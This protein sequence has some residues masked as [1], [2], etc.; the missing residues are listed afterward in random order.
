MFLL[1]LF[2]TCNAFHHQG[3]LQTNYTLNL[4]LNFTDQAPSIVIKFYLPI[5]RQNQ[6]LVAC[7]VSLDNLSQ[8]SFNLDELKLK[9]Q[10]KISY[11]FHSIQSNSDIQLVQYPYY[12][13]VYL[14][15]QSEQSVSIN[16]ELT[17]LEEFLNPFCINNCKGYSEVKNQNSSRCKRDYCECQIDRLGE[18]CQLSSSYLIN[19]NWVK[20]KLDSYQWKYFYYQ[21]KDINIEFHSNLD[22]YDN[23]IMYS[24]ELRQFNWQLIPNKKQSQNLKNCS[25]LYEI[26]DNLINE[27]SNSNILY[28]GFFNNKS[29]QVEFNLSIVTTSS[30]DDYDQAERNKLILIIIGSVVGFLLLLSFFLSI[31]NNQRNHQIERENTEQNL[32]QIQIAYKSPTGFN[33]QFI[34]DY[35]GPIVYQHIIKSYPGLS[36]F[37]DCVICLESLKDGKTLELKFCSV[38]PCFHIF[39]QQCLSTWLQKQRNCPFCRK[40]FYRNQ[41]QNQHPWI[42]SSKEGRKSIQEQNSQYLQRLKHT[43]NT[44]QSQDF[45]LNESQQDLV[46][47]KNRLTVQS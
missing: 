20:V 16:Y 27:D 37:E 42:D 43:Q 46:H 9:T 29:S 34:N 10:T 5:A 30:N 38:T 11:D 14:F 41:I 35:F 25:H 18:F 39:H 45:Q 15:C 23:S 22:Y 8:L 17:Y 19:N 12:P 36:Q 7:F 47:G 3:T 28:I 13:M 4:T 44:D 6:K 33:K 21:I 32:E 2:I 31:F 40:E 24:L 26:L 1:I